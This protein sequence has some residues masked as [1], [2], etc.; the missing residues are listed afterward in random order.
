MHCAWFNVDAVVKFGIPH[1]VH[2]AGQPRSAS[3]QPMTGKGMRKSLL[4][5]SCL[6]LLAIMFEFSQTPEL[7]VVTQLPFNL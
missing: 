2:F 3:A 6:L 1:V 5:H 7:L 4:S